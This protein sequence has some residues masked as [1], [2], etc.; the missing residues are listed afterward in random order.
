M[1]RSA[2]LLLVLA[3]A[4]CGSGGG[5]GGPG[6]T[7]PGDVAAN[8]RELDLQIAYDNGIKACTQYTLK[9]A[10]ELYG[11]KAEPKAVADAVAKTEADAELQAQARK[12]CLDAFK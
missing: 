11:V 3:L 6:T 8:Q 9:D 5:K 10:A 7:Q 12:G 1:R 2:L 4:G